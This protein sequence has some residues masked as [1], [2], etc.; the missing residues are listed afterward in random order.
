LEK[1]RHLKRISFDGLNCYDA[2]LEALAS[3]T[4]EKARNLFRHCG[5]PGCEDSDKEEDSF[6]PLL[7]QAVIYGLAIAVAHNNSN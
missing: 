7:Q 5:W 3:V 4:K 1:Y 2:H 6:G